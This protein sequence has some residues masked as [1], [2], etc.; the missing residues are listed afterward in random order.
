MIWCWEAETRALCPQSSDNV[1]R[2]SCDHDTVMG[3]YQTVSR[4]VSHIDISGGSWSVTAPGPAVVSCLYPNEDDPSHPPALLSCLSPPPDTS[5][6]HGHHSLRPLTHD[7]RP[8]PLIASCSRRPG[9]SRLVFQHSTVTT[10]FLGSSPGLYSLVSESEAANTALLVAAF[11]GRDDRVR[12]LLRRD[13][14]NP[15]VSYS[16]GGQ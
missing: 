14:T 2:L 16:N 6:D 7:L 13:D 11:N 5:P 9:R 4:S 8:R 12:E 3:E 1:A 10:S 15:N